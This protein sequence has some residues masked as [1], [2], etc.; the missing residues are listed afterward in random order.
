MKTKLFPFLTLTLAVLLLLTA[1]NTPTPP[2]ESTPESTT[3][4]DSVESTTEAATTAEP[5]TEPTPRTFEGLPGNWYFSWDPI[6]L[7]RFIQNQK[8]Y[9]PAES[10]GELL[11]RTPISY[12]VKEN[13]LTFDFCFFQE[14]YRR[15]EIFQVRLT[16]T[17]TS[18]TVRTVQEFPYY[19]SYLCCSRGCSQG[20]HRVTY[21]FLPEEDILSYQ[22]EPH[23]DA[24]EPN[25]LAP[26]ESVVYERGIMTRDIRHQCRIEGLGYR[27]V[28]I[29]T[30][31]GNGMELIVPFKALYDGG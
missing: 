5:E 3:A 17:N 25:V 26:G 31:G 19:S 1:C 18:D 6:E 20:P 21:D 28:E 9:L 23:A 13:G 4:P 15:G 10:E 16:V 29:T 27:I 2:S 24:M 11:F 30:D 14:E 8:E 22:R 7:D 12:R